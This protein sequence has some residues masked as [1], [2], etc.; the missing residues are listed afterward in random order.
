M[1][2]F[3][4]PQGMGNNPGMGMQPMG[5]QMGIPHMG[6]AMSPGMNHQGQPGMMTPQMQVS[7][8]LKYPNRHSFCQQ[9]QARERESQYRQTM[10]NLH[11]GNLPPGAMNS[12]IPGNAGSPAS[13]DPPFNPAVVQGQG[14]P[15]SGA[16]NSRMAQNKPMGMMPP[17]SPAMNGPPKDQNLKDAKPN[18]SNGHPEGSPRNAINA[19]QGQGPPN[20]GNPSQGGTAPP[21]PVPGPNQV[22]TAPSPS[23]ILGNPAPPMG[24]SSQ[25]TE[26]FANDFI[27][28]V[29]SSLDEFD[30]SIFR[31]EGG[32]INFERDFGQWFN[33]DDVG[34]LELK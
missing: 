18:A 9:Y 13:T 19:G 16:L 1:N 22:M 5:Q 26:L 2:G 8:H 15:F 12:L 11:K 27:Q 33:P 17:P 21:T 3:P 7:E 31:P 20:P 10:H 29:A 32:D 6:M 14:P 4:H 34:G 23:A 24:Q 25:G 30:P 28:S